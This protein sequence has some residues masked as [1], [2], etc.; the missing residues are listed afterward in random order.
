M[1][2]VTLEANEMKQILTWVALI[3]VPVVTATLHVPEWVIAF[4]AVWGFGLYISG[5]NKRTNLERLAMNLIFDDQ[6]REACRTGINK[7]IREDPDLEAPQLAKNTTAGIGQVAD[8]LCDTKG[9]PTL[10]VA[11]TYLARQRQAQA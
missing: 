6:V 7:A 1:R 10:W 4:L 8:R 3:G 5:I 11:A 9:D 2:Q